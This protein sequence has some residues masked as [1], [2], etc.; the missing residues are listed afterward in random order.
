MGKKPSVSRAVDGGK[1]AHGPK[2]AKR[3]AVQ[4]RKEDKTTEVGGGKGR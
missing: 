3:P 1:P 2:R 4:D